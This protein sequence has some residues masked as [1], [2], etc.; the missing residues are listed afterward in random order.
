MP[1]PAGLV[2]GYD[3]R[4]SRRGARVALPQG[5]SLQQAQTMMEQTQRGDG[6]E[7]IRAD[8][9]VVLDRKSVV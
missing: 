7:S 6:I 8:G 4:L 3:V 9:S 2:G 5:V 1:G